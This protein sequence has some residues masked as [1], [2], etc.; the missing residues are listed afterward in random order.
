MDGGISY[1]FKPKRKLVKLV[2]TN[3]KAHYDEFV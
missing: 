2:M 1:D 3:Q